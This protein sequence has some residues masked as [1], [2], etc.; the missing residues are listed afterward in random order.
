MGCDCNLR[1]R[2]K[3]ANIEL[4]RRDIYLDYNATTKPDI[5]VLAEVEKFNRLYW[6][7]PSAQNSRGVIQF[8]LITAEFT[9]CLDYFQSINRDY[10][11]NNSSTALIY[12]IKDTWKGE[13]ITTTIEH[14]SLKMTGD[15][16]I[17]VDNSGTLLLDELRSYI[18]NAKNPIFIYSA[19]NHET[20]NLQP[21]KQI[22]QLCREYNIPVI[23]DAVQTISRLTL[24][25]WLPYCNGFYYS[26]HKIYAIPG[27][28]TLIL[29]QGLM[30]FETE[31]TPLPFSLYK[32]TFNSPAVF[33]LIKATQLLLKNLNDSL[34]EIEVLD[35]DAQFIMKN[36]KQYQL[37]SGPNRVPGIINISINTDNN[38]EDLLMYLNQ[39]NIQT[40]RISACSGDI[41][42]PSYV[43]QEMGKT[44][45][46]A[47]HSIRV[48]FGKGS[49]RDDFYKLVSSINNFLGLQ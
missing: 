45:L 21:I 37:E 29:D 4:D 24:E 22:Y 19:V 5:E 43:L 48:S 1:K 40:G 26:G 23:L 17:G 6:G 11:F 7:N 36:L 31:D 41:N 27:A 10:Y 8:N 13:I 42:E 44:E 2:I 46:R 30:D 20:G 35:R 9:K 15:K 18:I 3:R 38:I 28:A 33:A 12:N 32:G 14:N 16:F 49:K 39:N 47:S 34:R 25:K